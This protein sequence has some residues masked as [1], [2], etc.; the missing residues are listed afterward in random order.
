MMKDMAL[1]FTRFDDIL[2]DG[3]QNLIISFRKPQLLH[4]GKQPSLGNMT[5][6]TASW[7]KTNR[8]QPAC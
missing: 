3:K 4:F 8:D 7:E 6:T 2:C 1:N 5:E